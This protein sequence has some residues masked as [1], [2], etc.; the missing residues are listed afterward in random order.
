[1]ALTFWK[2]VHTFLCLPENPFHRG[3]CLN[4]IIPLRLRSVHTIIRLLSKH[5]GAV[6]QYCRISA[7]L[8]RD[9]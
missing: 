1:M 2:F 7:A 8:R 6:V 5:S 9:K 3:L 4:P